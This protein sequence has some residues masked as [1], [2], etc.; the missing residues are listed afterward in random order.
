M[1]A[2]TSSVSPSIR[3]GSRSLVS[4]VWA[5]SIASAGRSSSGSSTPNSSPPSRAT[6]FWPVPSVRLRRL[7]TS[8]SRRSPA[9]WP[10]VSLIS[11]KW[12]RSISITPEIVAVARAEVQRL[13]D[14]VLEQQAVRQA[15]ERVVQRL[16]LLGDRLA[17]AAVDGEQRQ[18]QQRDRRQRE[19]AGEGDHRREAEQQ[20]GRRRLEEAV[21]D[22]VAPDAHVLRERDHGRDE[23]RVNEEKDPGGGQDP[24]KV[25]RCE[26]ERVRWSRYAREQIERQRGQRDRDRVLGRVEQRL[27]RR[28]AAH[29]VGGEAPHDEG[30]QRGLEARRDQRREGEG[31]GRRDLALDAAGDDLDGDQLAGERADREERDLRDEQLVQGRL[32][33]RRASRARMPHPPR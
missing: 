23:R 24:R 13:L 3:N 9:W 12:S 7:A 20:P 15:G 26:V 28:L 21:L 22:E 18:Q 6:V 17:T 10:S 14:A 31:G 29:H 1:L 33:A 27:Q 30:E 19:V 5:T 4:S 8:S 16:V 25:V 11:L 2:S 32:G